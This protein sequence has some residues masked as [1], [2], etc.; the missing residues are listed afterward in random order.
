VGVSENPARPLAGGIFGVSCA[1]IERG[2]SS[3]SEIL[4]DI[5]EI[6]SPK[7]QCGMVKIGAEK[8]R[9][10]IGS[11]EGNLTAFSTFFVH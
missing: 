9:S 5:A 4:R 2:E 6:D 1:R 3:D 11:R 10:F 8:R 7:S